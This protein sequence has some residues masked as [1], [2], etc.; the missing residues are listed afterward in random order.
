MR[1]R[2]ALVMNAALRVLH[3]LVR[4]LL[5]HGVTYP[6]FSAAIKRV[7]LD[8]AQA[9]LAARHMP[10]TDSAITLL[11]GVHRRDVRNLTRSAAETDPD[12]ASAVD[13]PLGLVGQVVARWRCRTGTGFARSRS[14]HFAVIE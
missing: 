10:A 3:P 8:A 9:E 4:L 5:R 13:E 14:P 7:F 11:S 12:T 1:S 2:S 6:V